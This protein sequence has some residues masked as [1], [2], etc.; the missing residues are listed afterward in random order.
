M[1]EVDI[2]LVTTPAIAWLLVRECERAARAQCNGDAVEL[3]AVART[4]REA[5]GRAGAAEP[6]SQ[7]VFDPVRADT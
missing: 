5:L 2:T 1:P 6:A 4:M 3:R 7:M